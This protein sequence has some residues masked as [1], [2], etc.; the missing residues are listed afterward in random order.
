MY[1]LVTGGAGF[2]G[3]H[4]VPELVA[5]GHKVH[6]LDV[7]R[8]ESNIESNSD[9]LLTIEEG[10]VLDAN[11]IEKAMAG[12][13]L[14]IHMAAICE[15]LKYCMMPREVIEVT[16]KGSFNVIQ[17]AIKHKTRIVFTSTSEV[18]GVNSNTPWSENSDRVLG[19]TSI[20]RWCYSSSKA[21]VE[22]YLF[23]CNHEN[24][25]SFVITRFF[26]VY[27]PGLKGRVV[28]KFINRALAGEPLEIHGNGKQTRAFC[29]VSD[30][31]EALK[32]IISTPKTC[33]NI[34]NIGQSTPTTILELAE[35]ILELTNSSS[36]LKFIDYED[37]HQGFADIP[38]RI[39][40]IDRITND[41]DWK[42][43]ISLKDG[44][45]RTI[46]AISKN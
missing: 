28:T 30:A 45:I 4:L 23:A 35:M 46:R 42:P 31:I 24:A 10:N 44:L 3:Q 20:S 17:S 33:D 18:Y 12:K 37:I 1:I 38:E 13:D 27:G 5:S 22:H 41:F 29:Y 14:V 25:L 16:L 2:I 6:V 21:A 39:P 7:Q 36:N 26:N 15:P 8:Y 19:S 32:L 9:S 34:Y 11:I 43:E 40:S